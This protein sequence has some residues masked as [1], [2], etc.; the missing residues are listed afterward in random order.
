MGASCQLRG[1]VEKVIQL[2]L[3]EGFYGANDELLINVA[4]TFSHPVNLTY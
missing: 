2:V 1:K 3:W 4:L